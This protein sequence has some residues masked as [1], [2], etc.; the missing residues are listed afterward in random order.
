MR[1]PAYIPSIF[2][3]ANLWYSS[4]KVI[5]HIGLHTLKTAKHSI[6]VVGG[7]WTF[8]F[9]YVVFFPFNVTHVWKRVQSSDDNIQT[10]VTTSLSMWSW[11]TC[12]EMSSA[13]R[14]TTEGLRHNSNYLV[15]SLFSETFSES[16]PLKQITFSIYVFQPA[17][18]FLFRCVYTSIEATN[19]DG[20]FYVVTYTVILLEQEQE[21]SSVW[22]PICETM[23]DEH[24]LDGLVPRLRHDWILKWQKTTRYD[25][26]SRKPQRIVTS[27]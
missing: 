19:E 5:T 3:E 26:H 12:W 4:L 23:S 13:V 17:L 6:R 22:S 18:I 27:R 11:F 1:N 7:E 10:T 2:H 16:L 20:A 24:R 21:H 8:D 9:F 15:H 25:K 14:I